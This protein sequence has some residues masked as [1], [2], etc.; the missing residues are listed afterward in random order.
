MFEFLTL[1]LNFIFVYKISFSVDLTWIVFPTGSCNYTS[2]L[3][4]SM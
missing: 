4:M 3:L 1:K 2:L